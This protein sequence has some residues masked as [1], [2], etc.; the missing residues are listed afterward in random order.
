MSEGV[1]DSSGIAI[2]SLLAKEV[3]RD[4]YGGNVQLSGNGAL[5]DVLSEAIKSQRAQNQAG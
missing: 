3:E 4:A 2:P 5:A 1:R